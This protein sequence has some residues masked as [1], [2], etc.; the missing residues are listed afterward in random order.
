MNLPAYGVTARVWLVRVIDADTIIVRLNPTGR[1][2]LPPVRLLDC[3]A[4][5]IA[6]PEKVLGVPAKHYAES[7]VE[8]AEQLSLFIPDEALRDDEGYVNVFGVVGKFQRIYGHVF[9]D[10]ETTLAEKLI[11]AGHAF[12]TEQE[13]DD[14]LVSQGIRV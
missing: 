10:S 3:W 9:I 14:Y 11:E 12:A 13:L 6:G 8:E 1:N 7:L 5:E 2:D 4:A